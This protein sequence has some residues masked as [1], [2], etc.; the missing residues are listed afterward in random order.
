MGLGFAQTEHAAELLVAING[1]PPRRPCSQPF[2]LSTS[3]IRSYQFAD[4]FAKEPLSFSIIEPAV[5][6]VITAYV[7]FGKHS[8]VGLDPKYVFTYLQICH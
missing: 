7:F 3:K 8:F 2:L 1:G 5:Q 6:S 4:I